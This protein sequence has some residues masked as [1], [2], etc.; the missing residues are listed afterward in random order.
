[1]PAMRMKNQDREPNAA[2]GQIAERMVIGTY[3]FACWMACPTSWAATAVAATER[4]AN[5]TSLRFTLLVRG[6]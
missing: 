6:S 2:I 3:D 4:P 5:T 1:M